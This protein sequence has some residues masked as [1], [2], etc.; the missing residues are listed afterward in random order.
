M[1]RK[2][3]VKG[4]EGKYKDENDVKKNVV[5]IFNQKFILDSHNVI[6]KSQNDTDKEIADKIEIKRKEVI[7]FIHTLDSHKISK[8][9]WEIALQNSKFSEKQKQNLLNKNSERE[10]T[11]LGKPYQLY[12]TEEIFN[13]LQTRAKNFEEYFVQDPIIR[14]PIEYKDSILINGNLYNL[15]II[16]SYIK[17]QISNMEKTEETE[18][19]DYTEDV[20][21]I[22]GIRDTNNNI[23]PKNELKNIKNEYTE[24]YGLID[25]YD[26]DEEYKRLMKTYTTN[27]YKDE[28]ELKDF[29]A[30]QRN[31]S[32]RPTSPTR[33]PTSPTR[34]PTSSALR[35]SERLATSSALRMLSTTAFPNLYSRNSQ[36]NDQL[37]QP[38]INSIPTQ[39][40]LSAVPESLYHFADR[41]PTLYLSETRRPQ[42]QNLSGISRRPTQSGGKNTNKKAKKPTTNTKV[43]PKKTKTKTSKLKTLKK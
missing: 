4:G 41:S 15:K 31:S 13:E 29:I 21:H 7:G 37:R 20:D 8:N 26:I 1:P 40:R 11:F 27:R 34:R 2:R 32:K 17:T 28:S 3:K 24:R 42:T 30:R 35:I 9:K 36:Q 23:I 14:E 33:R 10:L 38:T 22:D 19:V 39:K 6:D 18:D 12:T 5:T 16:Y 25:D 43:Q